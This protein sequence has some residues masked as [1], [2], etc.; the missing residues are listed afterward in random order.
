MGELAT[1][2]AI[3]EHIGNT[4]QGYQSRNRWCLPITR[5]KNCQK[6]GSYSL[7]KPYKL[8]N[9]GNKLYIGNI[10][11]IGNKTDVQDLHY[12]HY[13]H[14]YQLYKGVKS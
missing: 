13:Y 4:Y 11:N 9:N 8:G 7:M 14:Y 6:W 1:T 3:A 2:K 12:Y 10:G 5:S